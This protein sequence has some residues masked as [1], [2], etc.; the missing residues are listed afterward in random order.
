MSTLHKFRIA[1]I[2]AVALMMVPMGA[3]EAMPLG[4]AGASVTTLESSILDVRYRR[5]IRRRAVGPA[6]V[7][8]LF[9]ALIGGAIASSRYDNY[10]DYSYGPSYG[11]YGSPG[12]VGNPGYSGVRPQRGGGGRAFSGGRGFG[13]R[14]GG[15]GGHPAGPGGA[16]HPHR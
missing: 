4:I 12:Y 16:G 7:M 8:G 15:G 3:V 1:S 6:A 9:G 11:Y 14:P 5:P 2:L 13:G 10:S